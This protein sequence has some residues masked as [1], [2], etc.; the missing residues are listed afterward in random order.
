M[1]LTLCSG[2]LI[3]PTTVLAAAFCV[4]SGGIREDPLTCTV[5]L[6]LHDLSDIKTGN[7][8]SGLKIESSRVIIV[9]LNLL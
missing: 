4:A 3:N 7:I 8:S 1:S 6:G 2:T 5:Y 9:S